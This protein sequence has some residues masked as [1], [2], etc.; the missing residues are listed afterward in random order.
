MQYSLW[1]VN[2]CASETSY[3]FPRSY[4]QSMGH[5][6]VRLQ[7]AGLPVKGSRKVLQILKIVHVP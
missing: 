3:I 2:I 5:T 1:S 4:I 7:E 6:R